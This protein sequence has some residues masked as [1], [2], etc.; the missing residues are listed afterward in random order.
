MDCP[1]RA[2]FRPFGK[3]REAVK[4]IRELVGKKH[5]PMLEGAENDRNEGQRLL[6]VAFDKLSELVSDWYLKYLAMEMKGAV[7]YEE[8]YPPASLMA[9]SLNPNGVETLG[10]FLG[11]RDPMLVLVAIETLGDLVALGPECG[12]RSMAAHYLWSSRN[13]LARSELEEA[14]AY[15]DIGPPSPYIPLTALPPISFAGMAMTAGRFYIPM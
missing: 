3:R 9:F 11:S 10:R 13:P 1:Y 14:I 2:Q 6:M 7:H 15:S 4:T 8:A 5:Q 12:P